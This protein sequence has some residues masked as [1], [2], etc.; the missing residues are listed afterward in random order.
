MAKKYTKDGL[1]KE[2]IKSHGR[3]CALTTGVEDALHQIN[4]TNVL[5]KKELSNNTEAIKSM[6]RVA[7]VMMIVFSSLFA[8]IIFAL[9]IL[10][11]AQKALDYWPTIISTINPLK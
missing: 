5:H 9:I 11:G 2:L 1:I 6:T 3:V 8:L 7:K 4:D 10:A